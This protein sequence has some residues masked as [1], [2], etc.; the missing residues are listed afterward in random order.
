LADTERLFS[1]S[2][3]SIWVDADRA[4]L[5]ETHPQVTSPEQWDY[6]LAADF[7]AA[8]DTDQ[9]LTEQPEHL[10]FL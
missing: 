6:A 1:K 10:R 3:L 9:R 7:I 8:V 4:P 5:S 2:N